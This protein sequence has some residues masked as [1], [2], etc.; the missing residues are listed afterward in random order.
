MWLKTT[1]KGRCEVERNRGK[2]FAI[3]GMLVHEKY[4][5]KPNKTSNDDDNDDNASGTD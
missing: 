5:N 2:D 1:R 4:T 3:N